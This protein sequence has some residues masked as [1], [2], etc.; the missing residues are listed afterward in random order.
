[1][2]QKWVKVG[3]V[4]GFVFLRGLFVDFS[5]FALQFREGKGEE[6]EEEAWIGVLIAYYVIHRRSFSSVVRKNIKGCT[7]K[8][9]LQKTIDNSYSSAC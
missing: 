2:G 7:C 3:V 4:I 8:A 1:M 5:C 9:L 6:E